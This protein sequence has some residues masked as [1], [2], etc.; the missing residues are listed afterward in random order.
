MT[1]AAFFLFLTMAFAIAAGMV[2]STSEPMSLAF[3]VC[4]VCSIAGAFFSYLEDK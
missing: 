2:A 1:I 3:I 4:G